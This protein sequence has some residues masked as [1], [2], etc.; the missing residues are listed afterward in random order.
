MQA[1]H[2]KHIACFT[3]KQHARTRSVLH[4]LE[5]LVALVTQLAGAVLIHHHHLALQLQFAFE[6]L[7]WTLLHLL[8]KASSIPVTA[9]S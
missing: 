8:D 5:L 3:H 9:I 7:H 2:I 1:A 6:L 4:A